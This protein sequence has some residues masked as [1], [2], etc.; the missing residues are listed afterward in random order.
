VRNDDQDTGEVGSAHVYVDLLGPLRVEVG[1][2]TVDIGAAKQRAIIE[3]LAL[4]AGSAVSTAQLIDS[5]WGEAPPLRASKALQVYV[6]RLRQTLGEESIRTEAPGYALTVPRDHID[7]HVF[8]QTIEAARRA[9]RAHQSSRAVEL[10]DRALELWQGDPLADLDDSDVGRAEV[11]RLHELRVSALEQRAAA[12]T[13]MG[14]AGE[15]VPE[16]ERLVIEH[17]F[18]ERLWCQLMVALY[19]SGRQHDALAAYRRARRVLVDE[20]GIE[21]G[22][23]LRALEQGVLTLNR[24][25]SDGGSLGWFSHAA[26][27]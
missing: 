14:D 6:S 18:R 24:P 2:R 27:G 25:G 3:V 9:L 11:A 22:P 12:R 16:L 7:V 10:F 1:E 5:L 15:V 13:E 23:E 21:P 26:S 4:H 20:L 17:P 8:E 19:R